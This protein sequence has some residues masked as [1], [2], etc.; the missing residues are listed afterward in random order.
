MAASISTL[1]MLKTLFLSTRSSATLHRINSLKTGLTI[2][3][4]HSVRFCSNFKSE[5]AVSGGQNNEDEHDS[6]RLPDDIHDVGLGPSDKSLGLSNKQPQPL[7]W[8]LTRRGQAKRYAR[9]GRASGVDPSIMWPTQSELENIIRDE[10]E[11][12]PSLQQMQREIAEEKT[13]IE[14][15]RK[16]RQQQIAANMAKMPRLLAEHRKKMAEKAAQLQEQIAKK[17]RLLEEA[18]EKLGYAIDPRSTRFQKMVQEIEK[19]EKKKKKELKKK[20]IVV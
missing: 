8:N 7:N 11:W 17:N 18:K 6:S 9:E 14:L 4:I 12:C 20:G 13:V 2:S 10:K 1:N 3:R 19:E 5:I 15:K 16:K